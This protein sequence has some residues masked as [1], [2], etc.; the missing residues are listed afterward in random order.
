MP[1][2]VGPIREI[3]KFAA[4]SRVRAGISGLGGLL[5][6]PGAAARLHGRAPLLI[7]FLTVAGQVTVKSKIRIAPGGLQAQARPGTASDFILTSSWPATVKNKI[8]IA[9]AGP[10]GPGRPASANFE[11]PWRTR[12]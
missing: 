1:D 4:K 9:L 10:A 11:I 7:L 6:R 5:A 8:R 12:R 3:S 2:P